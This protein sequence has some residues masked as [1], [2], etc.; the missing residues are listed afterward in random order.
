MEENEN[1]YKIVASR[2][3]GVEMSVTAIVVCVRTNLIARRYSRFFMDWVSGVCVY[4]RMKEKNECVFVY[5]N[6]ERC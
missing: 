4:V 1:A 6:Y 3:K 5:I 2:K